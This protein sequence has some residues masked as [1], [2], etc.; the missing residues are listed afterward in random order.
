MG[1]LQATAGHSVHLLN[2]QPV[3]HDLAEAEELR[4][5]KWEFSHTGSYKS[6]E[7]TRGPDEASVSNQTR[8]EKMFEIPQTVNSWLTTNSI[9]TTYLS[10]QK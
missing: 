4:D 2:K 8:N 6:A 7:P 9:C 10:E 3:L 5:V 1:Q